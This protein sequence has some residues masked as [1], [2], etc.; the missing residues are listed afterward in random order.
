MGH[1]YG[2]L[3]G[4]VKLSAV[5]V[6]LAAATRASALDPQKAISQYIQTTWTTEAGLPQT[7]I[8]T[9][10]QT[11]DGYLWVGTESGLARFDGVRFTVYNRRNTKA[12]PT[13]YIPRLLGARDGSL[14]IGTDS[15]LVHR[16]N[17]VWTT[18]TDRDGLSSND[19]R[20][21]F[22]G[23][24]G[25]LWVGTARGL[26]RMQD[27]KIRVYGNRDGLPGTMATD[28]KADS[29]GVLWIATD[30]G[31]GRFDGKRFTAYTALD[32][33]TNNVLSALAI[34]PDGSV[35]MAAAHGQ[36]ARL[37]Q[38][39]VEN[40]SKAVINDDINALLFDHDGNLWIGFE[41]RG[42]ARLHNGVLSLYGAPNG[43][44]G[45]TV[46][47]FFEDSEHNLW[48]GLFDSGL[49]QLRDGKFT[50]F[51]KPEGLSSNIG[52]C[53]LQARD[54]SIWM[55]TSTGGLDRI[56]PNGAVRSYT[57]GERQSSETIH[58]ML[59]TRDGAI[60][61]GERHGVLTRFLNGRFETF[62]YERSKKDA[63]NSL[64]EDHDGSLIVGTYGSGVAR[65]KDGQFEVIRA[66]GEVPA[67]AETADGTMWLGTDGEGVIR[68]K[69][70]I[71]TNFTKAKGLL[72]DHVL[73]L[74]MDEQGVLWIGSSSGGLN[75][76]Q[77]G[78]I[79]SYTPD[80]G[81]FDSTVGNILEDNFGNLWMGSDNG[82]FR[83]AKSE[84]NDFANRRISSIHG[85]VYGTT[86]GLRSRETM[87]GGT[88]TASKGPGGRLWFSTMR[89]L[90]VVDPA[91]AQGD[92]QA[93]RVQIE[94]VSIN[95]KAAESA[96]AIRVG[97][98]ASR[99]EIQFTAPS[100]DAP[101]QIQFR[102]MLEGF[103]DHWSAASVRRS[104]DYTNL[105]PGRYRILVQASRDGNEWSAAAE[106]LSLAVVP[107]WYRTLLAY[108]SYALAA[109][110]LTWLV[111][112]MRTRS[113]K[114]RRDELERLVVER[115]A[116]LEIE[117]QGL[118]RAREA[119]QF[120]AAHD[121]LTGLWS[122]GAILEQLAREL[123][124]ATRERTVL[125]VILGD[126]DHFK[127]VND[128]HGHLSGDFVLRESAHRLVGLMRGYDAVGRYGGE[129]FLIL[130][131]GYDAAKNPARAQ[132]LV[133]VLAARP[134][135]CNGTEINVTCS[136]GV[137][138][139]WPWLDRTTIDDLIRR[140]DKALY[141]AKRNGRSRVEFDPSYTPAKAKR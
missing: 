133:D 43:L 117:K 116:Q 87:Q 22:E 64:L 61:F 93:L 82:V 136:F 91:R 9:I 50:T 15:G 57:G 11:G 113:L 39:R 99:L 68:I 83:I 59:Q 114:R 137:T 110:V 2:R 140:A 88:G 135:D 121:S 60:W 45:E 44:P 54:G 58:S 65:F 29:A 19:I 31:L 12:L 13:D 41:S 141:Q 98:R 20:A 102:S 125:S 107:P 3:W 104:A 127:A 89:G 97:P 95:G 90:S 74:A 35:W 77:D 49:V 134:F 112:E 27:G 8:Y 122:R 124:R 1:G 80:Q 36:L 71:E 23:S 63:I 53:G 28:L 47:S 24:D 62:K 56:L 66:T 81:L 32:G 100:F 7:S 139:T 132:D 79:T 14:W 67:M 40:E 51:G 126:L 4:V 129:E 86:D 108:V 72:S 128:T 78:R 69:D 138:I 101:G 42:L 37:T 76:I 16:K 73:A 17:G 92:D 118:M 34:A 119:L 105:P 109:I 6:C 120:Q 21:L 84:L 85:V 131:P 33:L 5:C 26:D 25:S 52:W 38:G 123:E 75:R 55:A 18:Y 94:E 115:T 130:L 96:P 10:A 106:P 70:G 103:D 46:E 111:V 48:V 30:A